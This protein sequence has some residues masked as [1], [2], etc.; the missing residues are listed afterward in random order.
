MALLNFD[1]SKVEP[2]IGYDALPAGKYAAMVIN[3]ELKTN[4]K[5]TGKYLKLEFQIIEG[6]FINR[7][8]WHNL[9]LEN[10]SEQA[11][12]IAKGELSALCRAAGVMQIRDSSELHNK[13]LAITLKVKRN[14]DGDLQN[15]ISKF[16]PRGATSE[17]IM[18]DAWQQPAPSGDKA[19][20]EK[21]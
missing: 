6:Q 20:W 18:S 4:S 19:P 17:P 15:S 12:Q 2:S 14:N 9:N 1:A 10:P 7:K 13:P 5:N 8:V 21:R 3:S 11:V 16:E